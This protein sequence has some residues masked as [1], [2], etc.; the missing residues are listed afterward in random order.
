M[1]AQQYHQNNAQKNQQIPSIKTLEKNSN[2]YQSDNGNR[3][4][5]VDQQSL[6]RKS[7]ECIIL[8]ICF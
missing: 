2:N 6:G 8:F 1:F 5:N 7:I 4:I 3:N